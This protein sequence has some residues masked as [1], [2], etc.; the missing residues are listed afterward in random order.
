MDKQRLL[1]IFT[2]MVNER[3]RWYLPYRM[4]VARRFY[5]RLLA[6]RLYLLWVQAARIFPPNLVLSSS[7][8][9]FTPLARSGIVSD[10]MLSTDESDDDD[11]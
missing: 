1:A 4:S 9:S 11:P 7:E 5:A 2:I 6:R 8:A 3:A 10:A